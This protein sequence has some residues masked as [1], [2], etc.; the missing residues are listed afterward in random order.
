MRALKA[1]VD[2]ATRSGTFSATTVSTY[3][4]QASQTFIWNE[5]SDADAPVIGN[6][7]TIA[8]S[9]RPISEILYRESKSIKTQSWRDG[10]NMVLID[11]GIKTC[12]TAS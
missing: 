1:N 7:D 8:S 5:G 6:V 4:T 9:S 12:T 11:A 3:Q 10:K 2:P